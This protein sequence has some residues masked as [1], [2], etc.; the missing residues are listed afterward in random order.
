MKAIITF[1]L[2]LSLSVNLFSQKQGQALIDSL[3]SRFG[4]E[5]N[6]TV[7]AKIL[8]KVGNYYVGVNPDSALKYADMGMKLTTRMKWERGI[9]AFNTIYGNI[10]TTKGQLDSAL[11]RYRIT[12]TYA[13]KNKDSIN[14]AGAYN[15]L[16]ATA[17][18]KSDYISAAKY[19][20]DAKEIAETTQNYYNIGIACENLALVYKYQ[21]NYDKALDFAQQSVAAYG[22]LN[23]QDNI[24][25]PLRLIGDIF[26]RVKNYDSTF[27]YYQQAL[28]AAK[29]TNNE[30]KEASVFNALA[31]YYCDRGEYANALN[32]GLDGRKIFDR[33]GPTFEDAISNRG[34]IG[35]CYLNLATQPGQNHG[36]NAKQFLQ[37]ARTYLSDA[38][39][40]CKITR[41][42]NS[43]AQ[44]EKSLAEVYAL[45]GDYKN[46]YENFREYQLLND[47][48][49]SQANKNK[50]AAIESQNEIDKKSLEIEKQKQ[51]VREQKKNV[52]I[53]VA[54]LFLM[55]AIVVL[56]YRVSRI[57]KQKNEELTRL[58][59]ELDEANK[60]KARFFGILNHDLRSPVANLVNFL[61]L[62]KIKPEAL[63][64]EQAAER[65]N[66]I[67]NS[68][69]SL[70]E[71]MESM[72][73]WSKS[74]MQ[75][76]KPEKKTVKVYDLFSYIKKMF[77][78]NE[79]ISFHF[80]DEDNVE[81][82]TDENYL[83][84][85]MHN[86][87]ANAVKALTNQPNATIEWKAWRENKK[88]YLSIIDNGPGIENE[89]IRALY[90]ETT[91]SSGTHGLGLHIIR[92]LAKAIHCDIQVKP[93]S[94]GGTVF[95]LII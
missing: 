45:S 51:A 76:F 78:D 79:Q 44:F 12:L 36:E 10:Y 27:Y 71:T 88:C 7:K 67:G 53:S 58:N 93:G 14:I 48:I 35:Y 83:R 22:H 1:I 6:D 87:T 47:S 46:A 30:M 55:A 80:S 92:D 32:A 43:Q 81:P 29:R 94:S 15:N 39:Q 74:Q 66:R 77:G 73:L 37:L 95:T 89:K 57:R 34:W 90:D 4:M 23:A 9:G 62:R 63:N 2:Y 91:T 86:L 54:G 64:K 20:T 70:L 49:F 50:L 41:N 38:V 72:L 13:I 31:E 61:T 24:I 69:Q 28:E 65:E 42:R 52:L 8:N 85:I 40:Q 17:N 19:Y 33:V 3:V 16:G 84:T 11:E 68:A 25:S 56:F 60:V 26:L 18:A 75:Y 21:E 59:K 82:E 5:T